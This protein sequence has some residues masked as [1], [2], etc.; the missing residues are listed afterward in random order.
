MLEL[1]MKIV[2]IAVALTLSLVAPA[3]AKKFAFPQNNPAATVTIPDTWKTKSIEYGFQAKSPDNDIFFS[4]ESA[5]AKAMDKMLADNTAWM[6][7]NKISFTGKPT[8]RD[9]NFG[10]LPGKMQV[11][12]A[13]DENGETQI[14]LVF[15]E[16][17]QRLI[18]ITLWAS[19]EEQKANDK[20]IN[21]IMSS[22]KAID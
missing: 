15:A 14:L 5:S 6:K 3:W 12:P 9:V 18:F 10:G 17:G 7:E 11:Y 4:I 21:T 20:D 8:E 1:F 16:A 22:I 13:K 2:C 19:E